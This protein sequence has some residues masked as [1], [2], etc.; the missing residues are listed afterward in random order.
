MV[1]FLP[2]AQGLF[3]KVLSLCVRNLNVKFKYTFTFYIL[4]MLETFFLSF[5]F[6]FR[7]LVRK[8][9]ARTTQPAGWFTDKDYQCLC[10]PGFT[11]DDC[12]N[13]NI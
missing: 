11:G 4:Y 2:T 6:V 9:L 5:T 3:Q 1:C 12:E 10:I 13:G 7:T 8:T